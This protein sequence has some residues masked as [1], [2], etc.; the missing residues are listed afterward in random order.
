MLVKSGKDKN[1][2]R[3]PMKLKC[4]RLGACITNSKKTYLVVIFSNEINRQVPLSFIIVLLTNT[5]FSSYQKLGCYFFVDSEKYGVNSYKLQF[6]VKLLR[7]YHLI[8]I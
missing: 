7:C 3:T 2:E 4:T 5:R 1:Q 6:H 8:N